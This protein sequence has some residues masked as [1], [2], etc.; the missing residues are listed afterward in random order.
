M[1]GIAH[2]LTGLAL[3]TFFPDVIQDAEAGSL[4]PV[5]GA[6]GGLLPDTL[7][8]KFV[9]FWE[10]YDIDINPEPEPNA[11]EIV[12][13][14]VNALDNVIAT[15]KSLHLR[16]NTIRLS[17]DTWRRYTIEFIPDEGE[18]LVS[19]GP[20]VTT[21]KKALPGSALEPFQIARRRFD[22]QIL[23][24]YKRCY[25]IDV[26][27]GPSFLFFLDG[28]SIG[29][30]FLDWH[31]RWT[32]S[33]FVALAAGLCIG[34]ITGCFMDRVVAIWMGVLC[35]L[36]YS[37]HVL[38]DH[39]GYLGCNLWWPFSKQRRSGLGLFHSGDAI[40]N[41]I[42]VWLSLVIILFNLDRYG[43][44]SYLSAEPYL[45]IGVGVP[46]IAVIALYI[47]QRR[48]NIDDRIKPD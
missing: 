12:D 10:D 42:T 16:A 18:I 15:G 37:A 7:D 3:A 33:L 2:F 28:Q 45:I 19:I 17:A 40:P 31:H 29:V 27:Q 1:K 30:Q 25:D 11:E 8:F 34:L 13:V 5:L 39:L 20:I 6:I 46:I 38:E 23:L 35:W 4:L 26:F 43:S 21:D 32:H 24:P 47:W 36:G 22:G 14:I 9:Q 48:K 41:F 44:T